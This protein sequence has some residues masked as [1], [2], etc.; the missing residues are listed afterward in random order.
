MTARTPPSRT[1]LAVTL[2]IAIAALAGGSAGAGAASSKG[3]STFDLYARPLTAQFM[4]HADDRVRGMTTNPFNVNQKT[5]RLVILTNGKEKV[6]GPFPG[7]DI[8]YTFKLFSDRALSRP[9]GSAIYTC[10]YDFAKRATCDSYF[11]L[12]KG[13]FLATGPVVFESTHFTLSVSGGTRSYLGVGGQVTAT[14]AAKG[15]EHLAVK[16][17]PG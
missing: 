16:L 11:E 1:R 3:S 13:T 14:P 8:L 2:A 6:K 4:N 9:A 17:L 7:D 10:Y 12:S 15:A 5:L